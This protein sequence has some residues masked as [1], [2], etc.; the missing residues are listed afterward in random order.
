M[1][2]SYNHRINQNITIMEL[3]SGHVQCKVQT[4]SRLISIFAGAIWPPPSLPPSNQLL[5]LF[6]L[7]YHH[8][9][10]VVLTHSLRIVSSSSPAHDVMTSWTDH[11]LH[12]SLPI[13]CHLSIFNSCGL[14]FAYLFVDIVWIGNFWKLDVAD[15]RAGHN[16]SIHS[17]H[18]YE[19]A[20]D[21]ILPPHVSRIFGTLADHHMHN[22]LPRTKNIHW[23]CFGTVNIESKGRVSS[24]CWSTESSHWC[25]A[26]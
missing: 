8:W 26:E 10:A 14:S 9:P 16:D 13:A 4:C 18:A 21:F 1:I 25:L 12:I 23:S 15:P 2:Y 17:F 24:C 3:P 11:S 19:L 7:T 20:K 5:N 22:D 6:P